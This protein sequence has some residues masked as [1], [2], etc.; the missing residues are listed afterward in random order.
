M[1]SVT[2]CLP[3]KPN[4]LCYIKEAQLPPPVTKM[5]IGSINWAQG[6]RIMSSFLSFC[7]L[8]IAYRSQEMPYES[9]EV[10]GSRANKVLLPHSIQAWDNDCWSNKVILEQLDQRQIPPQ[11]WEQDITPG[12]YSLSLNQQLCM[13]ACMHVYMCMYACTYVSMYIYIYIYVC[14][15]V[16]M[17]VYQCTVMLLVELIIILSS[18]YIRTYIHIYIQ[19]CIHIHIHAYIHTCIHKYIHIYIQ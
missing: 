6:N 13:H 5:V 10:V 16:C 2:D 4:V 11:S 17:H 12:H 9:I 14:M 19:T 3:Y 1:L 18:T 7:L 8:K 15:Y